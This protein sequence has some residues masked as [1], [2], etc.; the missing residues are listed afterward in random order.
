M[1]SLRYLDC[2]EDSFMVYKVL[3]QSSFES[4]EFGNFIR[5]TD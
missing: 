4:I 3:G 1:N 2:V 5:D